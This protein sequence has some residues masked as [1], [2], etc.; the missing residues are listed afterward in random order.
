MQLNIKSIIVLCGAFILI[1]LYSPFSRN[2]YNDWRNSRV[3]AINNE[4]LQSLLVAHGAGKH[5]EIKSNKLFQGAWKF[6]IKPLSGTLVGIK[7]SISPTSPD[8]AT[9]FRRY[10]FDI[11]FLDSDGFVLFEFSIYE[12]LMVA[13]IGENGLPQSLLF[14]DTFAMSIDVFSKIERVDVVYRPEFDRD[15]DYELLAIKSAEEILEDRAKQ[16]EEYEINRQKAQIEE[17]A[18][19]E[20]IDIQNKILQQNRTTAW[21]GVRKGMTKQD[22]QRLLGDP[23][24]IREYTYFSVYNYEGISNITFSSEGIVTNFTTPSL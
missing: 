14:N 9:S 12:N 22:I 24:S 5:F 19:R 6:D 7:A 17:K 3:L 23:I 1:C 21:R 20:K 13:I 10:I 16:K 18:A 15:K 8:R 11:S 2:A 4:K